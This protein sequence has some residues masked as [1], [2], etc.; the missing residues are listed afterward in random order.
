MSRG[1]VTRVCNYGAIYTI[2]NLASVTD[3]VRQVPA[4]PRS[5]IEYAKVLSI[6]HLCTLAPP[7]VRRSRLLEVMGESLRWPRKM[8]E[9]RELVW[10]LDLPGQVEPKWHLQLVCASL[11]SRPRRNCGSCRPIVRDCSKLACASMRVAPSGTGRLR[12]L[13]E[14]VCTVW[15]DPAVLLIACP[16]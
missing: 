3:S 2:Y 14:V 12:H 10:S 16:K 13:G 11:M 8:E 6:A 9:S 7:S 15:I 5:N 1:Y 4:R